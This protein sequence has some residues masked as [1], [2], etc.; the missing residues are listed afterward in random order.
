MWRVVVSTSIYVC[1][2]AK[3]AIVIVVVVTYGCDK[4]TRDSLQFETWVYWHLG[5]TGGREGALCI[6]LSFIRTFLAS[7]VPKLWQKSGF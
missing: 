3:S 6:D 7:E 2:L 1:R 5:Q 4:S